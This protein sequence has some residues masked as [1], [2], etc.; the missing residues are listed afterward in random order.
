MKHQKPIRKIFSFSCLGVLLFFFLC[1]RQ[2]TPK[3]GALEG[4]VY[5]IDTLKLNIEDKDQVQA[6]RIDA[7]RGDTLLIKYKIGSEIFLDADFVWNPSAKNYRSLGPITYGSNA[8][9]K[10]PASLHAEDHLL[11]LEID[12][13][14]IHFRKRYNKPV[15]LKTHRDAYNAEIGF[16]LD[17]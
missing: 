3:I 16:S 15:D 1:C 6:M 10:S 13:H 17:P 11:E 14:K 7:V 2:D 9:Y 5:V 8:Q 4:N 12:K